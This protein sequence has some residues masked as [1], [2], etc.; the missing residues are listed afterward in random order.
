VLL[1]LGVVEQPYDAV[2][3]VILDG[4]SVIEVAKTNGLSRQT[5]HPWL[6]RYEAGG[7]GVRSDQ[8]HRPRSSP[9]EM[10][11]VTEARVPELRRLTSHFLTRS[12][13]G[14]GR[15]PH[16]GTVTPSGVATRPRASLS[17]PKR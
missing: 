4:R 13:P 11:G 10:A 5:V 1:K 6:R 3:G 7:I 2:M 17:G 15:V 8:S 9:N 12:F 14:A 16:T